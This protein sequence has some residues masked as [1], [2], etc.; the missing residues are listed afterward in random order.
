VAAVLSMVT[1]ATAAGGGSAVADGGD[2]DRELEQS[3]VEYLAA[4]E[5]YT[6][7]V[8]GDVEGDVTAA[9]EAYRRAYLRY[10]ELLDGE[11]G[12]S[13]P[14]APTPEPAVRPAVEARGVDNPGWSDGPDD[15]LALDR[16][17]TALVESAADPG[18]GSGPVEMSEGVWPLPEV[19]G[20]GPGGPN[21]DVASAR[22]EA[23]RADAGPGV[24]LAGQMYLAIE[25]RSDAPPARFAELTGDR[26]AAAD[27]RR[28]AASCR[29]LHLC[30]FDPSDVTCGRASC[31]GC[32]RDGSFCS[33]CEDYKRAVDACSRGQA[34]V[35]ADGVGLGAA[36]DLAE[37]QEEYLRP[38]RR[39]VF[40][41]YFETRTGL[42]CYQLIDSR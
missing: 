15:R 24:W 13:E 35:T 1:A 33:M 16:L 23:P 25:P 3:R 18:P 38:H 9:L 6:E 21:Q 11:L 28:G 40:T 29:P 30:A 7:L 20:H 10:Q 32:A 41:G 42:D 2:R 5:R 39:S 19:D 27:R 4:L 17:L 8:M 34:W 31:Q 22:A 36:A 37:L 12:S 26:F 14:L